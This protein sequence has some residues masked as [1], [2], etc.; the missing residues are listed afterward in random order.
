[1]KTIAIIPARYGS[2]RFP[3]KPLAM[4]S[5]QPMIRWVY[6]NVRKVDKI[7]EVYVATD[8]CR[9]L[10]CVVSFGGKGIMTDSNH[11]CGTD[12][13]AECVAKLGLDNNDVVLN[14]QG[15]EP[16][17]DPRMIIDL[18]NIFEDNEVYM[19]T[20]KKLID[21]QEELNNPN[22]VKVITDIYGDAIYFS[23]YSLPYERDKIT[24]NHFK[25]IGTYGYRVWFLKKFSTL[26]QTV[27]EK[28]ESLEQLRVIEHGMKIRVRETEYQTIGVDVPEQIALVEKEMERRRNI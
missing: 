18:Y 17:I 14:I 13:I 10:N 27:L 22:V 4:I 12:R 8:D 21:N 19:G 16:L 24:T 20:L 26:S 15:D 11:I 2:S 23:R 3:G 5:G 6:E 7:D 28:S 9:I 1:M 25:H